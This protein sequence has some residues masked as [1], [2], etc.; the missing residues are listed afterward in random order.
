MSSLIKRLPVPTACVHR[1]ERG[2][3]APILVPRPDE[4]RESAFA[5]ARVPQVP[6][7]P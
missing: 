4:S 3:P 6:P 1:R 2:Q 7:V 5:E